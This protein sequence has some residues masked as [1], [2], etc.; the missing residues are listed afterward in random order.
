MLPLADMVEGEWAS[1]ARLSDEDP[2]TLRD[3]DAAGLRLD[4]RVRLV[5][6]RGEG[7]VLDV[8]ERTGIRISGSTARLVQVTPLDA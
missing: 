5:R 4:A 8:E 6:R 2:Q 3:L 7:L 1:V